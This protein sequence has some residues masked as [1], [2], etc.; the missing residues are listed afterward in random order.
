MRAL[1]SDM[2]W[3]TKGRGRLMF[4]RMTTGPWDLK[5]LRKG[6]PWGLRLTGGWAELTGRLKMGMGASDL[7][8]GGGGELSVTSES[9]WKPQPD[10]QAGRRE[11]SYLS[12]Q[13][14]QGRSGL[15]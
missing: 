13:P 9:N 3:G 10:W 12:S 15:V 5:M 6:F 7:G 4:L 8:R 14:A 1:G 2:A 11:P